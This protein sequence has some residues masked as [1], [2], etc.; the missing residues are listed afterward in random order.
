MMTFRRPSDAQKCPSDALQTTLQTAFKRRS[1]A[2]RRPSHKPP[3]YPPASEGRL[4]VPF[5]G[6]PRPL[7]GDRQVSE[8][9]DLLGVGKSV[10][11]GHLPAGV[12]VAPRRQAA[13]VANDDDQSRSQSSNGGHP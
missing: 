8:E 7:L 1:D 10:V 2:F 3:L 4:G 13:G 12:C 11:P 6:S 9:S 5:Q